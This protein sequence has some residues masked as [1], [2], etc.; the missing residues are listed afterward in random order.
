MHTKLADLLHQQNIHPV[1]LA[2]DGTEVERQTQ[3]LIT[4]SASS[5]VEYIIPT[6]SLGPSGNNRLRIGLYHGLYPFIAVQD[7][8]HALKTARNQLLTGARILIMG[9]FPA[10]F[11]QLRDLAINAAG[12]LFTRDVER[13]DR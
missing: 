6:K 3:D 5:N 11:A 8:K 1:S 2:S 10:F 13:L 7:S 12:P 4:D 9:F